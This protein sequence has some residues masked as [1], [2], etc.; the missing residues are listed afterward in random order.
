MGHSETVA[1]IFARGGSKGLP[2]K[3]VK[4]LGGKPLIAHAIEVGLVTPGIDRVIV[5]TDDQQIAEVAQKWGAE[6]PFVRPADLAS[7]TSSEWFSWRHAIEM[8]NAQPSDKRVGTFVSLPCTAP[9]RNVEDIKACLARFS[10]GD[11]DGVITIREAERSPY[12]NMVC[13][14]D[15]GLAS[16]AIKPDETFHR[17]QDVP[18]V[19]D[20][21]TVAYVCKP[22]FIMQKTGLFQGKLGAVM[23]PK[24]RAI[25][26]DTQ[27]DFDMA[28]F[29]YERSNA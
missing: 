28:A 1:F 29:F 23:I 25:D 19:F 7:D 5:S 6:V 15:E 27:L 10:Q 13:V 18:D 3:N 12:F 16:L 17:R 2:G 20:M 4:E 8:I 9:L 14:N 11:V 22:E 21:T 26:I 24:E